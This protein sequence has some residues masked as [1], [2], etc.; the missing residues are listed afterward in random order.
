MK[1]SWEVK[2]SVNAS[3]YLSKDTGVTGVASDTYIGYNW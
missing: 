1:K 3:M 2:M